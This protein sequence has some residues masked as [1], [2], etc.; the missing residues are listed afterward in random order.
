MRNYFNSILK[1]VNI[2]LL[3]IVL[4]GLIIRLYALST[5][6][7]GFHEDEAHVGYNAYSL[8]KT[9]R[10]KNNVFL[11][12]AIDQ[13]GDFRPSG[14]HFLTVPSVA[15]FGLSVFATRFP[16]A[17]VGSLSVLVFYFLCLEIFQNQIIA[18]IAAGFMV[19]TPWQ[20]IASRSTSES[21]VAQFFVI[22]GMYFMYR[23]V[24]LKKQS[25][26]ILSAISFILSFFFYHAAR[27]F[28]PVMLVYFF[29]CIWFNRKKEG[30]IL[31][32]FC[33][34]SLIILISLFLIFRFS[35][36]TNRP[37]DIS[38]F[39]TPATKMLIDKQVGYSAGHS[40]LIARILHNEL[41]NYPLTIIGNYFQHFDSDFLF[42]KG[43]LPP[44]YMVSGSG[45]FYLI[46]GLFFLIGL[47]VIIAGAIKDWKFIFSAVG[48]I[49]IWLIVGSIPA[50]LTYEDIPHFQRS[51]MML[52][53]FVMLAALGFYTFMNIFKNSKIKG[54]IIT[55]TVLITLFSTFTFLYSYFVEGFRY[56]P[57]YR[58]EGE[59]ELVD[60]VNKYSGEG[61]RVI[62]TSQEA[63]RLIFYLFYNKVDPYYYQVIGSPR[64]SNGLKFENLVFVEAPCP[65]NDPRALSYAMAK[66]VYVDQFDCHLP[67]NYLKFMSI[68]R[69]DGELMF[70]LDKLKIGIND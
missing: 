53:A 7:Y 42:F 59:K 9:F 23:F 66:T 63:N 41:I 52:P 31:K 60:A 70:Q 57:I 39:S 46:E 38:V 43:G 47:S 40:L 25:A 5:V 6:P 14:L 26:V 10:D 13:F 20:I 49:L 4:F 29:G 37:V 62:M 58:N 27:F 18:I 51:I 3:L 54:L 15:V 69:P 8:L 35:N 55:V 44:R 67:K 21:I 34:S 17:F 36:G 22:V 50:A 61:Y 32:S 65:T 33:L 68:T 19:I 12:L 1:P 30:K 56:Q 16:A 48:S 28:V 24:R 11:P 45:N 64:D 2:A